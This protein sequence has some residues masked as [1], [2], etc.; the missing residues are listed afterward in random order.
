M[1]YEKSYNLKILYVLKNFKTVKN[2]TAIP[3]FLNKT[4]LMFF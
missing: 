2:T 1:T 4:K 3:L